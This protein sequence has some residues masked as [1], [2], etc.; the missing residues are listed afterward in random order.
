MGGLMYNV[1]NYGTYDADHLIKLWDD[2]TAEEREYAD[3]L[4]KGAMGFLKGN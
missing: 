3:G 2:A 1:A 4:V